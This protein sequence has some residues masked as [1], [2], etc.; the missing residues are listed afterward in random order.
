[1][2]GQLLRRCRG[3]DAHLAWN[4]LEPAPETLTLTSPAFADGA[5]IPKRHAGRGVGENSAPALHID[6][7]PAHTDTLVLI[8]QDPDAPVPRP[9][10]HLIALLP[11]ATQTLAEG[12]LNAPSA[13]QF[14]RGSFG[15]IGYAGPR[16]IPGHG[17]H[18]YIFQVFA[19]CGGKP[20]AP[21]ANLKY[22]LAAL[23]GHLIARGRHT[24]TYER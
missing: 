10:V 5:A 20:L 17:P 12:A 8:L 2:L 6:G 24:G 11:P 15:R 19:A 1:M 16:P 22:V 18:R 4:R 13:L 3:R 23:H 9:I 21:G 7:V 14:G